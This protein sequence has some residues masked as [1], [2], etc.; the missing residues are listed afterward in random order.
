MHRDA[1]LSTGAPILCS[2]CRW[3]VG[4]P[5]QWGA[6]VGNSWRIDDD[7]QPHWSDILRSLDAAVGLSKYAGPGGWNDP[8]ILKVGVVLRGELQAMQDHVC[9]K[10]C[11][12]FDIAMKRQRLSPSGVMWLG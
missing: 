4:Q 6:S 7:L 3:G 5:W 2:L 10:R 1:L 11:A 9:H 12:E 8:D